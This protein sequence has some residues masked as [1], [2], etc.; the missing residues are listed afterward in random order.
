MI[1]NLYIAIMM[2]KLQDARKQHHAPNNQYLTNSLQCQKFAMK[3]VI[4]SQ[5]NTITA[6]YL[7]YF[8]IFIGKEIIIEIKISIAIGIHIVGKP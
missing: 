7:S 6:I 8:L 2:M 5:S 3:L 1:G 4:F